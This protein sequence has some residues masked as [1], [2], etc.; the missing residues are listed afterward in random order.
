[1]YSAYRKCGLLRKIS[2]YFITLNAFL[3]FKI[4]ILY[5]CVVNNA[6]L[7]LDVQQT[8]SVIHICY[9]PSPYL[10]TDRENKSTTVMQRQ[11]GSLFL[12]CQ[13][14]SLTQH[15]GIRQEPGTKDYGGLCTGSFLS[16]LQGQ[17]ALHDWLGRMSS[18]PVSPWLVC[19]ESLPNLVKKCSVKET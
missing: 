5:W 16:Q 3:P 6:V 9:T 19:A 13:G 12:A 18:R 4:F 17:L 7:V 10:R 11:E 8:N 14:P 1:M 15:S 2:K